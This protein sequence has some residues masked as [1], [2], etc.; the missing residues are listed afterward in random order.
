[1]KF[2]LK[3]FKK[4]VATY[5]ESDAAGS[6]EIFIKDMLYGIGVSC[7]KKKYSMASGYKKFK[8]FLKSKIL[9]SNL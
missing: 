9:P 7:D 4:Y 6:D 5:K 8:E 1:M 2:D 3:S